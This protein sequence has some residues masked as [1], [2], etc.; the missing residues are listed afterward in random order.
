MARLVG[1]VTLRI[2]EDPHGTHAYVNWLAVDPELQGTGLGSVLLRR[3][4]E[5]AAWR[6]L[7]R[8][9]LDTAKPA[10]ELVSWYEHRGY[11]NVD[12][13]HWPGKTYD[14]VVMEKVLA[15]HPD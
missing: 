13:T 14:S 7:S 6:G 4:E 5:E 15:E 2:K 11:R 9:R 3:G 12:E 10:T 8:V 1:T